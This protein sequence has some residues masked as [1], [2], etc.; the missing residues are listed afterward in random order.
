M[1]SAYKGTGLGGSNL[2]HAAA[3]ILASALSGADLSLGQIY[4]W[5]AVLENN[6]GVTY[7]DGNIT[8]G[9]SLTGGQETL[10]ALQGGVFDN[11]HMPMHLGL[12]GIVSRRLV[13]P[14]HYSTLQ[15]HLAL[16]NLGQ[17][18]PPGVTSAGVNR[19]WMQ[20]WASP[21]GA[22]QL[23]KKARLAYEGAEAL[24]QLDF[25][26]YATVIKGYRDLRTELCGQYTAG[27]EELELLCIRYRSE[28]FPVGAGGGTCLVCSPDPK[29]LREL[30][31]QIRGTQDKAA[32]RVVIPFEV[33]ENGVRFIGF[34]ENGL[35]IPRG[36]E[37]STAD[38][39][40]Q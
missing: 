40:L 33:Q 32:G 4:G 31:D 13:E 3:L 22:E 26:A 11:V 9:V 23:M 37:E 17:Q 25:A 5:G 14:T 21:Q 20:A 10:T 7:D 16:V 30:L 19:Q 18:R 8:Y 1:P 24:R 39:D 6:F 27:Q 35:N 29:D 34:Q 28:Y 15:N 38:D 2:A 36:P 12:H